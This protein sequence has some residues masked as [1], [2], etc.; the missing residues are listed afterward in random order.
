MRK[1][2]DAG[3]TFAN[4]GVLE[5]MRNCAALQCDMGIMVDR[6]TSN[7]TVHRNR[8]A[9]LVSMQQGT[10]QSVTVESVV[11]SRNGRNGYASQYDCSVLTLKNCCSVDNQVP[12][13]CVRKGTIKLIDSQVAGANCMCSTQATVWGFQYRVVRV[14]VFGVEMLACS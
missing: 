2:A 12:N 13:E 8:N 14:C 5:W 11:S 10:A 7:C 4:R 9:G 1:C 3:I 6:V